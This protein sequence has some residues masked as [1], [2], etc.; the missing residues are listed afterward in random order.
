LRWTI[1]NG[2]CSPSFDDVNITFDK[3][4]TTAVAGPDILNACGTIS[5]SAN[6]PTVGVGQ[7]T[8]TSNPDNLGN[9]ATPSSNLSN[10]NGSAGITYV[11]T[12][13]PRMMFRFNTVPQV[14][15]QLTQDWIKMF[16]ELAPHFLAISRQ[17]E[18]DNGVLHRVEIPMA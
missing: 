6:N 16:A 17:S 13:T 15:P 9:V 1:S 10:F 5:L 12:W 3:T 14:R 7:W 8:I 2:A 11:L 18:Q 4:P